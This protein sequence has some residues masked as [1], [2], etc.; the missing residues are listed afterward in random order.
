MEGDLETQASDFPWRWG[1]ESNGTEMGG[2]FCT[3]SYTLFLT[4]AN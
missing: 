3:S 1:Q 2:R 4:H